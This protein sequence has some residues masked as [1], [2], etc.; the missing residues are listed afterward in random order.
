MSRLHEV[1]QLLSDRLGNLLQEHVSLREVTS[2]G[3]GGVA[4]FFVA[5][6][7]PDELVRAVTSARAAQV[8]WFMIGN[9]SQT[10]LSDFG[11]PGLVIQ[12]RTSKIQF[13]GETG[14]V[15]VESGVLWHQLVIAAANHGLGGI[16]PYLLFPGT[17]GGALWQQRIGFSINPRSILRHV[18]IIDDTGQIRQVTAQA[19]FDE[20]H[21][22]HALLVA[23]FQL[24]HTRR[25]EIV[26][27]ITSYERKR[28][29]YASLHSGWLGPIFHSDFAVIDPTYLDSLFERAKVLGLREGGAIFS[30]KRINFIET[31]GRVTSQDVYLLVRNITE[32]VKESS[33]SP[34]RVQVTF[35]GSWSNEEG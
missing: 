18:T 34:I 5:A 3:V 21:T 28:R 22:I 30:E 14:Q 11:Y 29:V 4:D 17:I 15:L 20:V 31:R 25:D 1:G 33:Q 8:P 2:F 27:R 23:N 13:V 32:K 10:I 35:M 12:N 7:T 6:T 19:L 26:R 9:G 24:V 16:E